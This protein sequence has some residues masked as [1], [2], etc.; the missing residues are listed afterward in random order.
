V[1][2]NMQKFQDDPN[3]SDYILFFEYF[4]GD[5]G[6]GLGTSHQTGWTGIIAPLMHLFAIIN[7]EQFLRSGKM[8]Y[9]EL[10]KASQDVKKTG[11]K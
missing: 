5:N 3:C 4:N 11:S 10:K 8:A 9:F 1:Y 7:P 6:A 2:R